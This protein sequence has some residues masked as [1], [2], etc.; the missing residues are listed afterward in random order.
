[1]GGAVAISGDGMTAIA[2]TFSS[3]YAFVYQRS[4]S[5]WSHEATITGS[6]THFGKAVSLSEDGLTAAIGSYEENSNNG[7]VYVYTN[8]GSGNWNQYG[9]TLFANDSST[10]S[11]M[12]MSVA[13]NAESNTIAAGGDLGV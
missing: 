2:G 5:T 4:G 1:M 13:I 3:K 11:K 9:S 10:S 12:G 7:A 6:T 8:D